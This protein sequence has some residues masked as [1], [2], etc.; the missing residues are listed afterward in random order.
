MSTSP[1]S[2]DLREKV[3]NYLL[4]GNSQSQ[5]SKVFG[6]HENTI[7]RWWVRYHKEGSYAARKRLG[8]PSKV[9]QAKLVQTIQANPSMSLKEL[10][11]NFNISGWHA[12]RILKRLGFS[13]KK[14]ASLI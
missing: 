10:G 4:K 9:D 2:Q 6:L 5:A 14:K 12:S 3:I 7:N 11:V 13:Y 8:R 1:Y